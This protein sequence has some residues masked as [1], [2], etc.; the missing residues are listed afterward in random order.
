MLSM[1]AH[2]HYESLQHVYAKYTVTFAACQR[3]GA[4]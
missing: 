3:F 4:M 1:I 2:V